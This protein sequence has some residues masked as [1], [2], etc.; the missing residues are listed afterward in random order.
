MPAV[1]GDVR[2]LAYPGRPPA[3][4]LLEHGAFSVAVQAE[5]YRT[6]VEPFLGG[7]L[8]QTRLPPFPGAACPD[9]RLA[10][11]P[12]RVPGLVETMAGASNHILSTLNSKI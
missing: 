3:G 10:G 9:H 6:S 1:S 8:G 4:G 11:T 5:L 12:E 7:S 2:G